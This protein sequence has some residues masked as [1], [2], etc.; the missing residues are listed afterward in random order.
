M[1]PY[2]F[3]VTVHGM[4]RLSRRTRTGG[5]DHHVRRFVLEMEISIHETKLKIVYCSMLSVMVAR[6]PRW[7]KVRYMYIY[8][9]FFREL[10]V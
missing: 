4:S 5:F 6:L 2:A 10:W 8:I 3:Y 7:G 9:F 1:L